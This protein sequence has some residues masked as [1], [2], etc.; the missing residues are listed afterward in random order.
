HRAHAGEVERPQLVLRNARG[1]LLIEVGF[2][3]VAERGVA[4][5]DE[6]DRPCAR[7]ERVRGI[8]SESG[9]VAAA[10]VRGSGAR[11]IAGSAEP[12]GGQRGQGA[13]RAE[14]DPA[15]HR[16]GAGGLAGWAMPSS[17]TR[18]TICARSPRAC[19]PRAMWSM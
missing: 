4:S 8:R 5:G 14:E 19:A 3:V 1:E 18:C 10:R 17:S 16:W 2:E 7:G 6:R 11:E 12:R 13:C 9:A 15:V